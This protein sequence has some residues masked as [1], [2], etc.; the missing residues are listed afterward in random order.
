MQPIKRM[1]EGQG[2]VVKGEIG[3]AD[4]VACGAMKSRLLLS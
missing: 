1:L 3:A 4:V 2:Y